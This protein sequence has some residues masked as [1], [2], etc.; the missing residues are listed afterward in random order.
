MILGDKELSAIYGGASDI[1]F[2]LLNSIT[3]LITTL[4][5]LG[6]NVGSAFRYAFGGKS[7]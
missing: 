4:L 7:C 1:S 3:K 2:S 5:D 6:R